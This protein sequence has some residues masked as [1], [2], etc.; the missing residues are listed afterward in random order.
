MINE[1]KDMRKEKRTE[2][3]LKLVYTNINHISSYPSIPTC[4]FCSHHML[5]FILLSF[6]L[7]FFL[8][9]FQDLVNF[10]ILALL[11]DAIHLL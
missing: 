5:H 6:C 3:D 10:L 4:Y 1:I 7:N 9:H 8:I 11:L 2:I